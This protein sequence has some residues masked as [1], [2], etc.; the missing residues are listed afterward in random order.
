MKLPKIIQEMQKAYEECGKKPVSSWWVSSN[1]DSV[2]PLGALG[3]IE[4]VPCKAADL[5]KWAKAKYGKNYV[6]GFLHA[7]EYGPKFKLCLGNWE[8]C[9]KDY[10]RG[11][12]HGVVARKLF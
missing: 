11:F 6:E 10:H 7:L 12:R 3:L 4:N 1:E 8:A 2:C 9:G 5:C